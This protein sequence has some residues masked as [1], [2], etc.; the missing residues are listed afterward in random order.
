MASTLL[1]ELADDLVSS[2]LTTAVGTDT[3]YSHMPSNSTYPAVVVY[4]NGGEGGLHSPADTVTIDVEVRADGVAAYTDARGLAASIF[5]RYHQMTDETLET[6]RIL[7]CLATRPESRGR[8][9]HERTIVGFSLS[10]R[11]V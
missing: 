8:D 4:D 10:M 7:R 9:E 2:G 1:E 5:N 11:V 3:W 6:T